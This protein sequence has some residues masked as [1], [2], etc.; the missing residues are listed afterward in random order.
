[1][2]REAWEGDPPALRG[3]VGVRW[4]MMNASFGISGPM[5]MGAILRRV[6]AGGAGGGPEA[7]VRQRG[8]RGRRV[9]QGAGGQRRG[10]GVCS[11]PWPDPGQAL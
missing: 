5:G 8:T 10:A 11:A 3:P 7:R 2:G 9:G 4:L 6:Q 1:M